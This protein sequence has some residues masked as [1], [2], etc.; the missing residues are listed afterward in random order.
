MLFVFYPQGLTSEQCHFP[1]ATWYEIS[2]YTYAEADMRIQKSFIKSGLQN[3]KTMPPFPLSCFVLENSV[4][5][6]K[7]IIYVSM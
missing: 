4:V 6:H 3:Y 5:F 1:E 2:Q 7:H